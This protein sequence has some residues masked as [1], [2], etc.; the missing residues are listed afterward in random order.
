LSS[1]I[2]ASCSYDKIIKL[3]NIKGNNYYILHTLSNQ[4]KIIELKN[5]YLAPCSFGQSIAFYLKENI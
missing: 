4:Y 2:L 3:F 5:K 1:G